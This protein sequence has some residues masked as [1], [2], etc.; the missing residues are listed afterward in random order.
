M[1]FID[2][3]AA[4]ALRWTRRMPWL[5]HVLVLSGWML[6]PLALVSLVVTGELL[7]IGWRLEGLPPFATLRGM[8]L[9]SAEVL[10]LVLAYRSV[11]GAAALVSWAHRPGLLPR[12]LLLA[13][14]DWG[15][16]AV[17]LCAWG[18]LLLLLLSGL[19]RHAGLRYGWSAVP[20]GDA[21]LWTVI[22]RV[23]TPYF[24]AFL[25]LSGFLRLRTVLPSLRD[26][27]VRQY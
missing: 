5:E 6:G 20:P 2:A 9:F 21:A 24:Y 27:L 25:L 15:S 1:P 8:H 17:R 19:E 13:S 16:I 12:L 22:H 7:A 23:T 14:W 4:Q 26:Y 18:S 3:A 11:L 10:L